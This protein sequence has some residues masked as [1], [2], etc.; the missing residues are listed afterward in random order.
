M[1]LHHQFLDRHWHGRDLRHPRNS[2][3]VSA[4]HA[5]LC[6]CVSTRGAPRL[7]STD[8]LHHPDSALFTCFYTAF[9]AV[10]DIAIT[11][12]LF[13]LLHKQVLGHNAATDQVLLR[14]SR[15]ACDLN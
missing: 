12:G 13:A 6:R 3:F 1:D 4:R 14:V 8:P 10:I 7:V 5:E 2:V 11:A 9:T 15:L